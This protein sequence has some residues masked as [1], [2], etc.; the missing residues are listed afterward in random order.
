MRPKDKTRVLVGSLFG[1][2]AFFFGAIIYVLATVGCDIPLSVLLAEGSE[3]RGVVLFLIGSTVLV[4]AISLVLFVPIPLAKSHRL[5]LVLVA[6][7]HAVSTLLIA[8]MTIVAYLGPLW[9]L[10]KFYRE[11]HA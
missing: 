5:A 11:A 6:T 2:L 1:M 9:Y 8:Q 7:V 3:L 4:A 10:V